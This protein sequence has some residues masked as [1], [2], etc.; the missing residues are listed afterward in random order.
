M[1]TNMW[2]LLLYIKELFC[3]KRQQ[4][5]PRSFIILSYQIFGY[6]GTGGLGIGEIMKNMIY[7]EKRFCCIKIIIYTECIC[8]L[9]K[10]KLSASVYK[11]KYN[12]LNQNTLSFVNISFDIHSFIFMNF[13]WHWKIANFSLFNYSFCYLLLLFNILF[14]ILSLLYPPEC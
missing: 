11:Q 14:P 9:I 8:I 1:Q 12:K 7:S 6:V 2:P 3:N 5:R 10:Y 13:I 4:P